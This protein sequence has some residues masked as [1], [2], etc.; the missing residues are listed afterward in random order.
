MLKVNLPLRFVLFFG[1]APSRRMGALGEKKDRKN[2]CLIEGY[3]PPGSE[4]LSRDESPIRFPVVMFLKITS[5]YLPVYPQLGCDCSFLFCFEE[6][7]IS[8]TEKK[9]KAISLGNNPGVDAICGLSLLLVLSLAPRG[10]SPGTP[11]FPSP[12]KLTFPNSNSTRNQ[13]D[14][15]PLRGCATYKS[16]FILFIYLI[17]TKRSLVTWC[18][19]SWLG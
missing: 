13:V 18:L 10:F 12:Q 7:Q 1:E 8:A 15:E 3:K 9:N 16:L 17:R 19:V 5:L 4:W 2:D 11:V 6:S 14:E